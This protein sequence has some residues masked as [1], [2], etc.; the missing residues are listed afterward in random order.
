MNYIGDGYCDGNNNISLCCRFPQSLD[1]LLDEEYLYQKKFY[2]YFW[3]FLKTIFCISVTANDAPCVTSYIKDGYCDDNN[4][5][6]LLAFFSV[7]RSVLEEDYLY[8]KIVFVL[9][10]TVS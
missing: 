9:F 5:I 2:F 3:R 1:S 7:C 4:N 10:L 8:Q 6:S